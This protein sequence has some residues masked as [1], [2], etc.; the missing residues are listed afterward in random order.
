[1]RKETILVV[2]VE[3]SQRQKEGRRRRGRRRRRKDSERDF[4]FSVRGNGRCE[5]EKRGG[6]EGLKKK[7]TKGQRKSSEFT[8]T[9][10]SKKKKK[11][12]HPTTP[13]EKKSFSFFGSIRQV[14]RRT[15]D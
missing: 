3:E 8:S 15:K 14:R 13:I 12:F 7:N 10:R 11:T 6:E 4:I 2:G 5:R 9:S 1:M